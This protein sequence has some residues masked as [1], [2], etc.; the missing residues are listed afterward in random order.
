M[1]L[2]VDDV[3]SS[4]SPPS[5]DNDTDFVRRFEI[6]AKDADAA[7]HVREQDESLTWVTR[8]E[9]VKF[10]FTLNI[11]IANLEIGWGNFTD[12]RQWHSVKLRDVL[13]GDATIPKIPTP[14]K[15]PDGKSVWKEGTCVMVNNP[16]LFP[17]RYRELLTVSYWNKENFKAL[18]KQY[19][20]EGEKAKDQVAKVKFTECVRPNNG[21]SK[22]SWL[23]PTEIVGW[24]KRDAFDGVDDAPATSSSSGKAVFE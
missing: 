6:N 12:G 18:Y 14:E 7:V 21:K 23:F 2:S 24:T 13:T 5:E 8:R 19:L 20:A 10:P 16:E 4:M 9:V 11:D 3:F 15:G 17:E 22:M 1:S